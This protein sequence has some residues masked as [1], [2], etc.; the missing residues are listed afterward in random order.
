MLSRACLRRGTW[1]ADL[2]C[3]CLS[4]S[5]GGGHDN[6][7]ILEHHRENTVRRH[8]AR[9]LE[10]IGRSSPLFRRATSIDARSSACRRCPDRDRSVVSPENRQFRPFLWRSCHWGAYST[11][12]LMLY[13]APRLSFC[14]RTFINAVDGRLE[15]RECGSQSAAER[16]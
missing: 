9:N 7:F 4:P 13:F 2:P 10:R 1:R 3:L 5:V 8:E 16:D 12:R 15:T 14:S 11:A 6:A